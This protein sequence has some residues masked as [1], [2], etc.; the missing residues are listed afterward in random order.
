[1]YLLKYCCLVEEGLCLHF[2][3]IDLEVELTFCF[4]KH[5]LNYLLLIFAR[6]VRIEEPHGQVAVLVTLKTKTC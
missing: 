1:M 6:Q 3:D 5:V 4:E 2:G